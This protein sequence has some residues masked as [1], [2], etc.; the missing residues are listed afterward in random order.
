MATISRIA[1]LILVVAVASVLPGTAVVA[2]PAAHHPA[3]CHGNMPDAPA[4]APVS[5]QCCVTGH[6]SAMPS[7]AFNPR[8]PVMQFWATGAGDDVFFASQAVHESLQ[9]QSSTGSPP[10]LAPLRI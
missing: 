3:R 7:A 1:M 8:P 2:L 5:H 9:G 4:P 6:Q 10:G